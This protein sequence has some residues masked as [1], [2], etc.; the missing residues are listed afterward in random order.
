M[1]LGKKAYPAI[2]AVKRA[3]VLA[4]SKYKQAEKLQYIEEY[5]ACYNRIMEK[6]QCLSLKDLAV[7][8]SDLIAEGIK[9]GPG[10]GQILQELFDLVLEDPEK[11]EKEYLLAKGR[12]LYRNHEA[13][14]G[15]I[16]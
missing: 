15:I 10:L 11:N 4:Q 1:R 14:G 12:D 5:E 16:A 6:E 3:D 7:T 2:F 9:P 8:G 13:K